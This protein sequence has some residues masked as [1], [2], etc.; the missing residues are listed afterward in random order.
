M[1]HPKQSN[2]AYICVTI[3]CQVLLQYVQNLKHHCFLCLMH[4]SPF[5]D[6]SKDNL[7][8]DLEKRSKKEG[9]TEYSETY[10]KSLEKLLYLVIIMYFVFIYFIHYQSNRKVFEHYSFFRTKCY[11][12][13]GF[14]MLK[15]LIHFVRFQKLLTCEN[16]YICL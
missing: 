11:N 13:L 16:I 12:V 7:D 4:N 1:Q 14:F 5:I 15:A 3:V 6:L 9:H 2:I 8:D 10:S